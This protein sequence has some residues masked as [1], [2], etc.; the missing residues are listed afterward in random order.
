VILGLEGDR[1]PF[2]LYRRAGVPLTINT[3]D[4]GVSRSNLTMEYV[5]AVRSWKLSYADLKELARNSLEYSFLPGESLFERRDYCRIRKAYR[6]LRDRNW[7]P[8]ERDTVL[9]AASDK[10]AVQA[11]LE[12]AFVEFEG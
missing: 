12:R 7:Q 9:L 11:R 10:A 3:D 1:H 6:D 2:H 5:R 8:D 4:E